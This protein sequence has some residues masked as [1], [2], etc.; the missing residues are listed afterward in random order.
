MSAALR[1]DHVAIMVRDLAV[2]LPYY[3]TLLATLGW[4]RRSSTT[5]TDG[6]GTFLQFRQAHDGTADY[7]RYA[8]GMNH[9]GFGAPSSEVVRS[10]R[11]RMAAAGFPVPEIQNLGGAEALFMKDPDGIRFEV[12]WYPPGAAVVDP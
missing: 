11:E 6:V 4:E 2:S 7:G 3:E 9:L 5:W 12:T 8:P 1:I 10:V